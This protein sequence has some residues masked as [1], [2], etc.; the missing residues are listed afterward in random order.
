MIAEHRL[1]N[2]TNF[3]F[4]YV[5]TIFKYSIVMEKEVPVAARE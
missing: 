1:N 4:R 2:D 5:V 3:L